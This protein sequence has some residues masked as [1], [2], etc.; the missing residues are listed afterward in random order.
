MLKVEYSPQALED[1]EKLREYLLLNWD[2]SVTKNVLKKILYDIRRLVQYPLLG[3]N[4]GKII[5]LPTDYRFHLS[6][7]NYIFYRL[8]V[9]RVKI[10]RI[11]NEKQ[12][13]IQQLFGINNI[14]DNDK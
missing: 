7:K 11:L 3:T 9:D 2:E 13:Y 5:D 12:D 8:E 6:K 1:L 14:N 10:V 4:L